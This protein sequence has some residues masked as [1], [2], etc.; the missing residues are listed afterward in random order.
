M[1]LFV[2]GGVLLFADVVDRVCNW[3]CKCC[4]LA[5]VADCCMLLLLLF[6]AVAVAVCCI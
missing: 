6:V 2:G 1:V 4:C 5:F 3:R